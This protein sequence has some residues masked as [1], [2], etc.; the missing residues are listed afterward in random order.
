MTSKLVV[1]DDIRPHCWLGVTPETAERF[2]R[3]ELKLF[4]SPTKGGFSS[5]ISSCSFF[6]KTP[7]LQWKETHQIRNKL[8]KCWEEW[9]DEKYGNELTCY[10]VICA[11]KNWLQKHDAQGSSVCEVLQTK[12]PWAEVGKADVFMSHVQSEHPKL[13]LKM[14]HNIGQVHYK[15]LAVR[16]NPCVWVDI[17]SLRHWCSDFNPGEIHE[18]IHGIGC[19]VS[20]VDREWTYLEKLFCI[21][22]AYSAV[23]KQGTKFQVLFNYLDNGDQEIRTEVEG[24]NV[25][26]CTQ[27]ICTQEICT[28]AKSDNFSL[29]W[30]KNRKC[31]DQ[32]FEVNSAEATTRNKKQE[33]KIKQFIV[34]NAGFSVVDEALESQLRRASERQ[35]RRA[36]ESQ[37]RKLVSV[38]RKNPWMKPWRG[39]WCTGA[40]RDL[41]ELCIMEEE[42]ERKNN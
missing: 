16:K 2:F 18:L 22:E 20:V 4:C 5:F 31:K 36:S 35:S 11:V 27:E 33:E 28:E 23:D 13:T 12:F 8:G 7:R 37:I 6:H 39:G 9:I 34:E 38:C 25:D 29:V 17:F 1:P 19:T 41:H 10:D 40:P 21:F 26:P 42:K 14:M 32:L 3:E 15:D 24:D 30:Q